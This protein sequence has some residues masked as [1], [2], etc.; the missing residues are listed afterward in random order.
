MSYLQDFLM[1][2]VNG[3]RKQFCKYCTTNSLKH[4]IRITNN[5]DVFIR[6]YFEIHSYLLKFNMCYKPY[7][8]AIK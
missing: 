4:I 5:N 2:W 1:L 7:I 6:A 8:K 3:C